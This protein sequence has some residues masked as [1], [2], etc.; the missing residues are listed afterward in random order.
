MSTADYVE[1]IEAGESPV[2]SRR[3]LSPEDQVAEA[4]FMELR[5]TE[6][7]DL[8]RIERRYGVDVWA[9]WG[10][11]LAQYEEAGLLV[12]DRARMRLTREGMLLANEIMSTFL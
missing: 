4:I 8:P 11:A 10:A 9:R 2:A 12:H 6:G 5:L 1:R 7:M 3:E